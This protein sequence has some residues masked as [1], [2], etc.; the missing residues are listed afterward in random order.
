MRF[1]NNVTKEIPMKCFITFALLCVLMV[2]CNPAPQPP[3][4]RPN[5][6]Q[7]VPI[8][9]VKPEPKP[10]PK[11]EVKPQPKP[12]VKPQPK[13]EVKPQ[14]KPEQPQRRLRRNCPGCPRCQP[15]KSFPVS[16]PEC[17]EE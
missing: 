5:E 6:L 13:P 9:P 2:G 7:V 10:E 15:G 4:Y 14:P 17:V 11:P 3:P 16:T 8:A 1:E 12:E